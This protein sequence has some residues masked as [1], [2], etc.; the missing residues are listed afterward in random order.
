MPRSWFWRNFYKLFSICIVMAFAFLNGCAISGSVIDHGQ[1]ET[2]LK[3]MYLSDYPFFRIYHGGVKQEI[4]LKQIQLIKINPSQSIFVEDEIYYNAEVILQ[5]GAKIQ[6]LKDRENQ[7]P[8]YIS[9]NNTI[10]SKK[11]MRLSA[12]LDDL[13]Q[14]AVKK[15]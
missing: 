15:K 6:P 4:P 13:V 8:I 1:Y 5:N 3:S 12:S 11:D 10:K 7:A 9:V 2:P 14:I